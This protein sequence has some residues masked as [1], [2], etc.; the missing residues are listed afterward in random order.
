MGVGWASAAM[1]VIILTAVLSCLN[2]AFYV[3]S[4]VLF[5]LAE[6]GD[7]PPALVR[8]NARKVPA[9]SVWISALAGV[10]GV[11][12]ESRSAVFAFLINNAGSIIVFVYMMV[13]VAQ[14]RLRRE[15]ERRGEPAPAVQM[16]L[17]PWASY[18]ALLAMAAL[19]IAMALQLSADLFV[20]LGTLVVVLLAYGAVKATRG[21]AV[22]STAS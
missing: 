4:R 8:L 9:N 2:S 12:A 1:S 18:A 22:G 20:S 15:R 19:L 21:T 14:I 17:F 10:I 13:I 11:L 16:W 6:H 5:V 7:A 3:C